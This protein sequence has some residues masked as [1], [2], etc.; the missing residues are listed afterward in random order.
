MLDGRDIGTVVCPEAD[1]KFFVI[2]SDEE[3][4]RR[5]HL[6]LAEGGSGIGY[7]EVLADIRTRDA[8]DRERTAAPLKPAVD[9]HLLD[10]TNLDIEAAFKAAVELIDTALDRA[11]H[12]P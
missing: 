4:A 11:G 12:T 7:D 1:V 10:T 5:R 3:R 2:A 9:A 6:E 8:R